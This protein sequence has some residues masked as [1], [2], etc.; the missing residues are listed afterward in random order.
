VSDTDSGLQ[1][2]ATS[3]GR[4]A[5]LTLAVLV[6]IAL[7]STATVAEAP[8]DDG[9]IELTD[10]VSVWSE[11]TYAISQKHPDETSEVESP[12]VASNPTRDVDGTYSDGTSVDGVTSDPAATAVNQGALLQFNYWSDNGADTEQFAGTNTSLVVAKL[13]DPSDPA[14]DGAAELSA[15]R[16]ANLLVA[17][18]RNDRA[19]FDTQFTE[20]GEHDM[21]VI[22]DDG[23]FASYYGLDNDTESG[24]YV[25]YVIETVEG[26]G[27]TVDSDGLETN[28]QIN[29]LGI[30]SVAVQDGNSTV[31][32][33]AGEA[34][35]PVEF[36][37]SADGE[38]VDHTVA[39]FDEEALGGEEITYSTDQDVEDDITPEDVSV[40]GAAVNGVAD[41]EDA[42]VFG[43]AVSDSPAA[44]TSEI[45]I[46]TSHLATASSDASGPAGSVTARTDVS[47]SETISVG[48]EADWSAGEYTYVHIAT[49]DDGTTTTTHGTV[50]LAANES[51]GMNE[52]SEMNASNETADE[53]TNSDTP[54]FGLVVAVGALLAVVLTARRRIDSN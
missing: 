48:T 45:G 19:E 16:A 7:A 32:A 41:V 17:D 51:S 33:D 46:L 50:Q 35:Q 1:R 30:D 49:A 42:T 40:D 8:D 36:D 12:L 28:G 15:E 6:A 26:E 44:H 38:N 54:G 25:L 29:V 3:N 18:D 34:G 24:V 21:R 53:E 37:V 39:L 20:N 10:E 14:A 4:I 9:M 27:V 23:Y 43:A 52:S 13:D 11:S 22:N 47:G 31:S 5:V 2:W